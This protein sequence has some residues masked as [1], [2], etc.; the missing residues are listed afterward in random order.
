MR[1]VG[2]IRGVV[3]FLLTLMISLV[4]GII[5]WIFLPYGKKRGSYFLSI[6]R[7]A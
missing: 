2:K 3:N 1:K 5:L 4:S 7:G 6:A